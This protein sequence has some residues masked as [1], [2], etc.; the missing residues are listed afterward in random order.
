M[1]VKRGSGAAAWEAMG[2]KLLGVYATQGPCELVAIL[3]AED[4]EM[5]AA[6]LSS[7]GSRV[8]E[9]FEAG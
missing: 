4:D 2:G 9:V 7:R 1:T 8:K 3:V 5:G 6:F